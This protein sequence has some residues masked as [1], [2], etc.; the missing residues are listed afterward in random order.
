[1]VDPVTGQLPKYPTECRLFC[2]PEAL[3]FGFQCAEPDTTALTTTGT[4]WKRDEVEIFLEPEKDTLQKPYHQIMADAGGESETARY[5]IYPK[6]VNQR[7][8]TE[9]W[10]P[11]LEKAAARTADGWTLVL[12]LPFSEM[13]MGAAAKEKKTLWRMNLYRSRPP[14]GSDKGMAWS[15]SPPG[16]NSFQVGPKFGFILPEPFASVELV[17]AARA[18]PRE[19]AA[20]ADPAAE[21]DPPTEEI[22][23]NVEAFEFRKYTGAD[24]KTLPYRLLKP[25]N[26][27]PLKKYPLLLSLHGGGAP[28]GTDNISQLEDF[29]FQLVL[30]P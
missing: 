20:K 12:K 24:G 3:Y 7:L 4:F 14:R 21:E 18:L 13:H 5:H 19:A 6:Y 26:Y 2:T 15:W 25:K 10:T 22:K 17:T 11:K 23:K 8:G 1:M 27:D 30:E 16:V 29:P 9:P 28:V